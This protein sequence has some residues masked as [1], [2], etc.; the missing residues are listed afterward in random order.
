MTA[1]DAQM[2]A[3]WIVQRNIMKM[4]ERLCEGADMQERVRLEALL[5]EEE[6][7]LGAIV[8]EP[9]AGGGAA[10]VSR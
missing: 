2:R 4:R 8:V 6:Q 9:V 7:K 3:C 10:A 5:D 1:S